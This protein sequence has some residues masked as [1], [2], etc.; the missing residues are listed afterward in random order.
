MFNILYKKGKNYIPSKNSLPKFPHIS[1]E[2][3]GGL[4][5]SFLYKLTYKHFLYSI[6]NTRFLARPT[7]TGT[8]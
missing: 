4:Y 6:L 3:C 1:A 7:T 5:T 2:M 8:V